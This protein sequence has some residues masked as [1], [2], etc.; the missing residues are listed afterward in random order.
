VKLYPQVDRQKGTLRVEVQIERLDEFLWPD[1]SARITVLD[2]V[3]AAGAS[4][5]LVPRSAIRTDA[6]GTFVWVVADG[7]ARRTAIAAGREFGEQTHVT[8]G[9]S[10]DETVVVGAA[11]TLVDGQAI[12][13]KS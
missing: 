11:P 4:A 13:P 3:A 6:A 9:L 2:E 12:A 8:S 5:V 7:R 1:M 10:G